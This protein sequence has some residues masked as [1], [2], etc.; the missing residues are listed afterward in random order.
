LLGTGPQN[1]GINLDRFVE[2]GGQ[3]GVMKPPFAGTD[4]P[5]VDG[6]AWINTPRLSAVSVTERACL[7][8]SPPSTGDCVERNGHGR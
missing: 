4:V 5:L 6:A 3:V 1:A 7:R 8:N 2:S